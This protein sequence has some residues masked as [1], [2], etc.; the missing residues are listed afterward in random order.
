MIGR[1][2]AIALNTFREAV[3][4][5]VLYAILFFAVLLILLSLAFGELSL[6]E[7]ERV[8]KDLGIVV[9][10]VFGALIAIYTGISLLFKELDKKTIY[11]IVS[12]PIHRWQF[13][14]GKYLGILL[15]LA[16]E[17]GIMSAIFVAQLALKDIELNATLFQALV[18]IYVEVSVVAAIAMLFTTFSTPF[19]S[20]LLTASLFLLGNAHE[21]IRTF[22]DTHK[23]DTMRGIL[24][25][26]EVFVP[27]LTLFNLSRE[28]TYNLEVPW[29]YVAYAAGHGVL[30]AGA[31]LVISAAVF[32]R[33]DFI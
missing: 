10:T 8:N 7:Q 30:Y 29:S 31:L 16:V 25:I 4:S 11:T 5:E 12:K 19:L 15:T 3:R 20:G 9:I 18:L 23:S 26:A 24:K 21:A 28:V 22:A 33:R 13:L 1:V 27:D 6:Y 14:L 17:L 2:Y 32:G